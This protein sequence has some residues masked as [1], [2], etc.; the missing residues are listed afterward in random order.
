LARHRRGQ[1]LPSGE[2]PRFEAPAPKVPQ[3]CFAVQ[4][5]LDDL[6][7]SKFPIGAQ[8]IAAI[9]TSDGIWMAVRTIDV[10]GRTWLNWLYAMTY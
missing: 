1:Y 2:L 8:G 4:I 9:Y 6:D 3:G 5:V 10:R 7:Q